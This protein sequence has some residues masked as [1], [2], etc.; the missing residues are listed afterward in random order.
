MQL[1]TPILI[2]ASRFIEL[3][4]SLSDTDDSPAMLVLVVDLSDG[5][6]D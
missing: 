2:I 4:G 5:L 6:S 3:A 1:E